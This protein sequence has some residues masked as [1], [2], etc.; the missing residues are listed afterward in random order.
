MSSNR[1]ESSASVSAAPHILPKKAYIPPPTNSENRAL[2]RFLSG[3]NSTATTVFVGNISEQSNDNLIRHLLQVV[4]RVINWRRVQGGN[5]NLEHFG[6][7]E[8]ADQEDALRALRL[9][10]GLKVGNE[11]LLAKVDEKT[12]SNLEQYE[13]EQRD[14]VKARLKPGDQSETEQINHSRKVD[15]DRVRRE[16]ND[17]LK[18]HVV[19]KKYNYHGSPSRR[20]FPG[21]HGSPDKWQDVPLEM[22]CP[23]ITEYGLPRFSLKDDGPRG[24]QPL[25]GGRGRRRKSFS[26]EDEEREKEYEKRRTDRR[27]QYKEDCY[28]NRLRRWQNY[29]KN[30]NVEIEKRKTRESRRFTDREEKAKHMFEFFDTYDDAIHDVKYYRGSTWQAK[31]LERE[32]E[33]EGDERDRRCERDTVESPHQTSSELESDPSEPEAIVEPLVSDSVVSPTTS[34]EKN[35]FVSSE[36]VK[37]VNRFSDYK[38]DSSRPIGF[39]IKKPPQPAACTAPAGLE[40]I[41]VSDEVVEPQVLP[42]KVRLTVIDEKTKMSAP[43]EFGPE[44]AK[45]LTPQERNRKIKKL[46]E[47][48]PTEKEKLFSY[49]VKWFLVDQHLIDRRVTPW[50]KKRIVEYL[51]EEEATLIKYI[52]KKI[53]EKS[54]PESI[55]KDITV[56][57]DEEAQVFVIKLWRLLIYETEAKSMGLVQS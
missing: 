36:T 27:R 42:K 35:D 51:G 11:R 7:V 45:Y 47:K 9:I 37:T 30:L 13:Q 50:L 56:I 8:Y 46:I 28:Q 57:L 17:L 15:D 40:E 31:L 34:I 54:S 19:F 33:L 25:K 53:I 2:F 14:Y 29:E 12:Q 55:L 10:N 1:T 41:F 44:S 4:G 22:P 5:A 49:D 39:D 20:N 21:A 43:V 48:I 24:A 6:F 26:S 38:P 3:R 32:T 18:G 52:C 23:I 16:L